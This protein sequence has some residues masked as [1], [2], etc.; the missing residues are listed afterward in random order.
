MNSDQA[1]FCGVCGEPLVKRPPVKVEVKPVADITPSQL[2]KKETCFYHTELPATRFCSRCGC[3]ICTECSKPYGDLYFCPECYWGLAPRSTQKNEP[4]QPTTVTPVVSEQVLLFKLSL[5]S[6]LMGI[7]GAIVLYIFAFIMHYGIEFLWVTVPLFLGILPEFLAPPYFIISMTLIGGLLAGAIT[8]AT[9]VRPTLLQQELEEIAAH[10]RYGM[11]DGIVGMIRGLVAILFGA[12]IGPEGPMTGACASLGTWFAER[13]NL[14]KPEV[15]VCLSAAISGMF[16]GF[17]NTPV[18]WPILFVEGGLESGKLSWK[19]LLPTILAGSVG[20]GLFFVLTGAS[21]MGEFIVPPVPG[22]DFIFLIY[23]VILGLVGALL[24]MLFV[25]FF[26]GLKRLVKRWEVNHAIE[27]GLLAGLVLGVV[28]S[29]FPLVLFDGASVNTLTIGTL[30]TSA[31]GLGAPM[32]FL[33]SFMKLTVTVVCLAFGEAGGFFFPTFFIGGAM[34]LAIN[35]VF[36]FIPLAI[37]M[38][39]IMIGI[40]MALAKV[41]IAMSLI[42]ALAFGV[43]LT[44]VVA[45]AAVTAYLL[46]YSVHLS[47]GDKEEKHVAGPKQ[48]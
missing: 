12:S 36:P 9:K 2:K 14:P 37:C 47:F 42:I 23:A 8:K 5:L 35:L 46:T 22:F 34:G 33:Y 18:G 38:S 1:K 30:I 25:Y 11:L 28:A 41:P 48:S 13:A 26:N 40:V 15:M 4:N 16:G 32:V 39:C 29:G 31:A 24:G 17:L 20:A 3:P 7:L 44:G 10:G 6:I 45:V 43:R 19:V 21:F 27:L